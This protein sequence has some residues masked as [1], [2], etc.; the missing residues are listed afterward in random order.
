MTPLISKTEQQWS[1]K[2]F[3]AM[4]GKRKHL[5]LD[6]KSH[7]RRILTQ[8]GFNDVPL[9]GPSFPI[10]PTSGRVILGFY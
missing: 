10:P 6:I 2:R 5:Y 8:E 4:E 3:A 7:P 1:E 9:L